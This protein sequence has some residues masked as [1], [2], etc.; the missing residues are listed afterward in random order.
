MKSLFLVLM[1]VPLCLFSQKKEKSQTSKRRK[2]ERIV[3]FPVIV[4]SPEYVWGGGAAGTYFFKLNKD[5]VTR[6]SS[7]KAVT[8]ATVRKQLVA[9]TEAYVFFP[10]E[11]YI[12]NVTTSLSRFPDKFWGLGNETPASNLENYAISQCSF[13]PRLSRKLFSDIYAGIGYEFQNVFK[14]DYDRSG[15]SLF[16]SEEILG[17]N[18]GKT[19]AIDLLVSW[20]SRDHAFSP[21]RGLYVQYYQGFFSK[22]LGSDFNFRTFVLDVRKYFRLKADMTLAFQANLMATKGDIPI[23]NL[24]NIGS[25]SFMRGYY[26]GR[27]TDKDLVAVQSELR[28]K[29]YRRWGL[30]TFG[31][32]GKVGHRLREIF[33][34]QN[35]KPSYGV[36]LRYS[37]KPKE[38]L[39]FRVDTGF[40]KKSHG[41]Y[42][43]VG[44]A[45]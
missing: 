9:A 35:V 38:K 18:G 36:G 41:T 5:S 22:K 24:N 30:T 34:A 13:S 32:L 42:L 26:E 17:R 1:L 15:G 3:L 21:S 45:F 33:T 10:G 4:K 27:Y 39:N 25:N 28:F 6:T 2:G 23:R 31:G 29:V 43:N 12:L 37:L 14:F 40:G 8:F 11:H 16:D 44:E 19:S 20:D 7:I